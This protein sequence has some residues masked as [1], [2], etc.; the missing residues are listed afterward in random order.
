MPNSEGDAD[1]GTDRETDGGTESPTAPAQSSNSA[2]PSNAA[3]PMGGS[4][5]SPS[6]SSGGG[7][8]GVGADG[9][10]STTFEGNAR[11]PAPPHSIEAEQSLLGAMLFD[12]AQLGVKLEAEDFYE[13][14]HA[15]IFAICQRLVAEGRVANPITVAPYFAG[16]PT[17]GGSTSASAYIGLLIGQMALGSDV[18]H[19]ARTITDLAT[20]RRLIDL[21]ETVVRSA[22]AMDA[23]TL[24]IS[25]EAAVDLDTVISRSRESKTPRMSAAQ[26]M[27][28]MI[29]QF[30][31]DL[32]KSRLTTGLLDVDRVLGGHKR[33]EMAIWAA[34]PSMGKSA[35]LLSSA[36]QTAMAG[37]P[38]LVFSLEMPANA[39][40]ARMASDFLFDQGLSSFKGY[41]GRGNIEFRDILNHRLDE[42]QKQKIMG[43]MASFVDMPLEIE[44]ERSIGMS[45]IMARTRKVAEMYARKNKTLGVVFVDHIGLV[46]PSKQYSG[47]RNLELGEITNALATLAKELDIATVGLC[48]L[49]RNVEQREVK[50][51]QL[52]D[53]RESGRIEED[54]ET[55]VGLY[56]PLYYLER[57]KP[58]AGSDAERKRD[59]EIAQKKNSLDFIVLKQRN[60]STETVELFC[61]IGCNA[62]RNAAL[63]GTSG[64]P[65]ANGSVPDGG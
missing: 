9:K 44:T 23:T 54:A 20:R 43:A 46:R 15:E 16:W 8:A 26:A 13:P 65:G 51:P 10:K 35:A 4:K 22:Y 37:I 31:D 62:I 24:A 11:G 58:E 39:C 18:P 19:L 57:Q 47:D 64:A 21:G 28:E 33:G 7:P 30:D 38:A 25:S 6:A 2:A 63:P 50:F 40:A 5:A 52:S 42:A 36:R 41:G 29:S 61:E 14:L 48:Q 32:N 49:N 55:V 12:N 3:P 60:G 1:R 59:E 17:I 53:L 45:E 56:R 34:R 27:Q